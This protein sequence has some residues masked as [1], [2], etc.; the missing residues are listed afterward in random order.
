MTRTNL[1]TR[2]VYQQRRTAIHAAR[3]KLL[4]E[5]S[6]PVRIIEDRSDGDIWMDACRGVFKL[7]IGAHNIDGVIRFENRLARTEQ[8]IVMALALIDSLHG[9]MTT[10]V[11]FKRAADKL[12]S[13]RTSEWP[14]WYTVYHALMDAGIIRFE[15]SPGGGLGGRV[16]FVEEV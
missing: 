11:L 1:S 15:R 16:L 6:K 4:N 7:G 9:A 10:T 14:D 2:Q 12:G 13:K 5:L 8:Q 3:T